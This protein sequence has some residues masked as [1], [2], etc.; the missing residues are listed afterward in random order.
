MNNLLILASNSPRRKRLLKKLQI[1]FDIIPSNLNENKSLKLSPVDFA[2]YWAEKKAVEVGKQKPRNLILGADTIISYKNQILGK[3]NNKND[4]FRMLNLL[5]GK[6][7]KAITSIV[8]YHKEKNIIQS[9]YEETSVTVDNIDKTEIWHYINTNNTLDK[10]G[11]YG[12]Q[13]FFSAYISNINGCFYNV[14]GLPISL[15]Y[16]EY[17]KM[18]NLIK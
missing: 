1:S 16:K 15:L 12:I 17:K 3:P 13:G 6:T 9:T 18:K 5:S 7:H 11:A 10:A 4:S 2:T 14:M 8:F